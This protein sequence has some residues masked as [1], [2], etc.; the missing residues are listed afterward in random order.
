MLPLHSYRR[1][2]KML[3]LLNG[4]M[5]TGNGTRNFQNLRYFAVSALEDEKLIKKGN[6]HEK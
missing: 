1:L 6:V 4:A 5:L 3:S 2:I